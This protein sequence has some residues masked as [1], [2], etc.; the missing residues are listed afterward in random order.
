[1]VSICSR[2]IVSSVKA[3]G[4]QRS[5]KYASMGNSDVR[6]LLLVIEV[7]LSCCPNICLTGSLAITLAQVT[8]DP[9]S[10]IDG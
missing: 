1:M 8:I 3:R 4:D 9:T 7:S 5:R 10:V 2:S 6:E